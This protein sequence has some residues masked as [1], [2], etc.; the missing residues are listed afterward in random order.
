MY[1]ES[2][3]SNTSTK[4]VMTTHEASEFEICEENLKENLDDEQFPRSD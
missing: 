4:I 1:A 2:E 3:H